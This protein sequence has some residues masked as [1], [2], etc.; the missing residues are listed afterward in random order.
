VPKTDRTNLTQYP[1]GQVNRKGKWLSLK[2]KVSVAKLKGRRCREGE[3][4]KGM[5]AGQMADWKGLEPHLAYCERIDS[6]GRAES[7]ALPMP[8]IAGK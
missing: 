8:E 4:S 1:P 6:V 7:A 2:T 3:R 5:V